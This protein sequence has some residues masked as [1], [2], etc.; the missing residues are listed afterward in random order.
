MD[1]GKSDGRMEGW[2]YL[3]RSNR[4]G[5]QYSRK[6]YFILEESCLK[7]FKSK[8]TSDSQEPLRSAVI[9]SCIRVTDNGRESFSRKV[10]FIFSLY[11]ASNH[12]DYLISQ[13]GASNP[14]EAARWI[15]SLQD[16]AMEPGTNSKRR[17]QPYRLSDP[18][19]AARKHS[20]DWTSSANMHVDAMTSDVIA[21]SQWKIFGCKNGLR[22]F[23]EAKD[24]NSSERISSDFPAIMAVGVIEGT[25]EAVFRTFMSLG[26]SRSE[27]DFCFRNGSVVEHLDGHTDI[28]HIQLCRDWLPWGMSRRDLLLRRYWRRE[29]DGTY[30]ILC[31]SVIHSK[32]PPQ[33]GY[34][35]ACLLSGGFVMSPLNEGKEC[36]VKHML[37]IDW[38]LWRSYLPKTHARSMTIRMLGRVSALKELFRAK[39][40]DQFPSEFL[41]GEVESIHA[42]EEQTKQDGD[43]M[44]IED[45]KMEDA[46]DAP[47]S[48][49]SSL[50]GLNDTSDE[51]YDVPE[52]SEEKQYMNSQEEQQT[53]QPTLSTAANFVK[54]LQD[55]TSQN[56]GYI[57]LQDT[58][59]GS[60]KAHCYGSTLL[61][62]LTCNMPCTW[63]AS[64]PSLFLVRGPNYLKD[65][66]KNKAKGTVMEMAGA[67]WLQSNTREDHLAA[68]PGG[69]VQKYAAK[70]G[71]EFF[72]VINIQVPGATAY[73]LVLYYMTKTPLEKSPSLERFVNG[74]DAF[75]NSRF[76][77]IPYISKGSWLV[78]QSVGK[79]A[80]LVG[81]AL[82]VNYFRGDNYLELDIDVG[83][84]TV[85]RGVV[86]LVLGY[87]NNL[88]VEMAFVIQANGEDEL[89]ESLLGTCRLNHMDTA[90]SISVDTINHT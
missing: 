11:N 74:D 62:D 25:C 14:E 46:K 61:K 56:K 48:C 88:I 26:L 27:W 67:D 77:L 55:L 60:T 24:N 16:V 81:Q 37:S 72:F 47:V 58:A 18:M 49:S 5:L 31:H 9:D 64:D 40:G 1:L 42:N 53:F 68:R 35:R 2:L 89:P 69:I 65:N 34:V 4:F 78:K 10:F 90:K 71:P 39:G 73:N 29:D 66:Q 17:W 41:T 30:V 44:Q 82:E 43:M 51:F 22:L 19:I 57:E 79:K 84:S 63:A 28:I 76:K 87:L 36:V 3:I 13:L 52:P 80:C 12:N 83:S 32:C 86:N 15:H 50:I 8:P 21:P 33:Q 45:D 70:G 85:A 20:V 54:K 59:W 6:R 7:S 75:R 38:K 23:K